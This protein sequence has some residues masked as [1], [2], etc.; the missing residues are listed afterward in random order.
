MQVELAS[1]LFASE[2]SQLK[3]LAVIAYGK[4]GRHVVLLAPEAEEEYKKWADRLNLDL[5]EEIQFVLEEGERIASMRSMRTIEVSTEED[6]DKALLTLGYPYRVLLENGL[7]DGDFILAFSGTATRKALKTAKD[8]GWLLFET[9]GGVEGVEKHLL[10]IKK[11]KI[12]RTR[13]FVLVDSDNKGEGQS[14][15]VKRVLDLIQKLAAEDSQQPKSIGLVL[16]R[17]AIENYLPVEGFKNWLCK[18]MTS[19]T[20][21][22]VKED[23]ENQTTSPNGSKK[24]KA[25][26]ASFAMLNLKESIAKDID[27]YYDFS[28]GR[29]GEKKRTCDWL[30]DRLSSIEQAALEGGFGK[31]EIRE[32]YNACADSDSVIT[33]PDTAIAKS[34]MS[35]DR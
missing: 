34:S 29:C 33:C 6:V 17:R 16:K 12:A 2:V 14:D 9:G 25:L 8:K 10:E 4:V 27:L 15:S 3:L 23:W 28:L 5:K 30:W 18:E 7:N 31:K 35:R 26:L 32:F 24:E 22:K 1:N 19:E 20:V 11:Q 21:N 13:F